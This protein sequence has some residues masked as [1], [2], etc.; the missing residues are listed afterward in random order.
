[1]VVLIGGAVFF[2]TTRNNKGKYIEIKT[3]A[4]VKG[5]IKSYLSTTAVIK[6]KK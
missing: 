2:R 4:V 1:M 3:A 5:D 6:S